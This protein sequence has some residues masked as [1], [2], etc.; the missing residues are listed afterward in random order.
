VLL[1]AH[2]KMTHFKVELRSTQ[3]KRRNKNNNKINK[4]AE[5]TSLCPPGASDFLSCF[6]APRRRK[7]GKCGWR[8]AGIVTLVLIDLH[9]CPFRHPWTSFCYANKS[10]ARNARHKSDFRL[11]ALP[12]NPSHLHT[13]TPGKPQFF[14]VAKW[15]AYGLSEKGSIWGSSS[16]TSV[17]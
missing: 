3:K 2:R 7:C 17:C 11:T 14:W 13:L 10:S 4:T 9:A 15:L 16:R 8:A 5:S 12:F 6:P 1:Q